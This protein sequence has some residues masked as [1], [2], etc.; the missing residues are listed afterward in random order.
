MDN[1]NVYG[2]VSRFGDQPSIQNSKQTIV[3]ADTNI[4][5]SSK[6]GQGGTAVVWSDQMTD[7]EGKINARGAEIVA[8]TTV[9]N[10]DKSTYKSSKEPPILTMKTKLEAIEST[11]DPPPKQVIRVETKLNRK[12]I[13]LH[14]RFLIKVAALSRFLLK[15]I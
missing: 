6:K 10:A 8:L 2:F 14:Q 4:D 1:K 11:V 12:W 5:V 3:K 13:L 9:V 15:I 7:F